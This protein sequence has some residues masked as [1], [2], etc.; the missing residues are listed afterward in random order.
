MIF[1]SGSSDFS[2]SSVSPASVRISR[3]VSRRSL[4]HA[5][6]GLSGSA[7]AA[8]LLSACG[9]SNSG[10]QKQG[11]NQGGSLSGSKSSANPNGY[12][13]D[14]KNYS[15]TVEYTHFEG[16][17]NYEPGTVDH[18]PRNA[19]KP[20]VTDALSTNTVAGFHEA[21]AYFAAAMDYLVKTG[22][23]EAFSTGITLASKT[24][25]EVD[26]LS[27]SILAGVKKGSWYVNPAA[28]YALSSAQPS[29]MSDGNLLFK[30]QYTLDFG[31]EAVAEGKVQPVVN[32][33]SPSASASAEATEPSEDA[34]V[35]GEATSA[36]ASPSAAGLASQVT[37]QECDFRGR[38]HSDS[39]VWELSVVYGATLRGGSASAS[40]SAGA[41]AASAVV[42]SAAGSPSAS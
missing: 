36:S 37:V 20:Q 5:G 21:I 25:S 24:R 3:G 15:G 30:G 2:A 17:M 1:S 18:P 23:A 29:I 12:T 35:S 7:V 11:G 6:L 41:S 31:A 9:S 32:S 14:G 27:E 42:S 39:K 22:S 28:S 26:A 16:A 4:I 40:A 10:S 8:A 34:L 13:D 33:A 38:Y 19:P